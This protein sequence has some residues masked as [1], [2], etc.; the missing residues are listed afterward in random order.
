M[1]PRSPE[2]TENLEGNLYWAEPP[3]KYFFRLEVFPTVQVPRPSGTFCGNIS[4]HQ[5]S[6]F[7]VWFDIL[8]QSPLCCL[9]NP[10]DTTLLKWDAVS[11]HICNTLCREKYMRHPSAVE[12]C[13][14]EMVLLAWDLPAV[15]EAVKGVSHYY[16]V[17]VLSQ[18]R[19]LPE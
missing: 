17:V 16:T 5:S 1:K 10:R 4:H 12:P 3:G 8:L 2:G 6:W 11:D 13:K 9:E 7:N 19:I 18:L 15:R 14:D